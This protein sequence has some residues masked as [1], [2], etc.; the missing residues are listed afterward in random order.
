MKPIYEQMLELARPYLDTRSNDIHIQVCLRFAWVLLDQVQA[1]EAIVIPAIMLHDL[2]WKMIPED[3]QLTAFGPIAQNPELNRRH[4]LESVRLAREILEQVNYDSARGQEILTIIDGHDSRKHA[5]SMNDQMV[6]DLDKLSRF[7]SE[8][9]YI[10]QRRFGI[11]AGQYADWIEQQIEGWFFLGVS[12]ELARAEIKQR[13]SEIA[14]GAGKEAVAY[15]D[16]N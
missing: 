9:F 15:A 5:L 1:D 3:L 16:H 12:K 14:A 7:T 6:K 8:G 10:D 11:P 13:K 2:G 4:E